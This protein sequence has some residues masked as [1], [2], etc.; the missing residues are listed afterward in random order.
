RPLATETIQFR[1][2]F[3]DEQH[4]VTIVPTGHPDSAFHDAPNS[5]VEQLHVL[6][7]D[8]TTIGSKVE[9]DASEY[10]SVRN[11]FQLRQYRGEHSMVFS[12]QPPTFFECAV[13]AKP[14][15]TT[16]PLKILMHV[17]IAAAHSWP[18]K[19]LAIGESN[20]PLLIPTF[21]EY[22]GNL[23]ASTEILPGFLGSGQRSDFF[24]IRDCFRCCPV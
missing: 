10:P 18:S 9:C 4:C 21:T 7:C 11:G 3:I 15:A 17:W 24:R 23:T 12:E 1:T 16:M 8:R 14:H 13:D 5:G 2:H 19:P 20:S 6:W 22:L